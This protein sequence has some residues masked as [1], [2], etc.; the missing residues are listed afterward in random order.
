MIEKSTFVNALLDYDPKVCASKQDAENVVDAFISVITKGV[1][2][3]DKVHLHGLGVF[4]WDAKQGVKFTPDQRFEK[5]TA[6]SGAT[7]A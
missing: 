7:V 5:G 3:R 6:G 4:E 2:N 1:E